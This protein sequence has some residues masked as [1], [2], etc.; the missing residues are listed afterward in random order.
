VGL[1]AGLHVMVMV[2]A[3]AISRTPVIQSEAFCTCI[4]DRIS[5][6]GKSSL[7]FSQCLDRLWDPPS[8]LSHG[9]W[10][11]F[12]LELKQLGR[13]VDHSPTSRAKV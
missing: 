5:Q 1:T 2:R 10:G 6:Q 3:P 7:S 11:L 8:L 13:E 12:A 4:F 9:H